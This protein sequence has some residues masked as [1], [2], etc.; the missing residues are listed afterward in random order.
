M[1]TYPNE[2]FPGDSTIEALDGT[3]DALTGLSYVAKGVNPTSTPAY[4]VQYNRRLQRQ[5]AILASARQGMVV[6]EGSL[7]IG[8]YPIDYTLG[9]TRK[10]FAG[11][12][13]SG[14]D[15]ATAMETLV[16]LR[17]RGRRQRR[18]DRRTGGAHHA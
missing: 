14:A 8:V 6:D 13:L 15:A 18:L 3:T 5:N 2:R 16:G 17:T 12:R 9:G 1:S 4:E 7:K 10:N 11:A